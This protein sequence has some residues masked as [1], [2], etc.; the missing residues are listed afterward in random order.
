LP[1]DVP[2]FRKIDCVRLPVDDLDEAIDFY[3]RLGHELIWR[4]SMQ[5]GL[6]LPES[7]AEIVLQT[8]HSELEVDFVVDDADLAA[9]R[10][11]RNGGHLLEGPCDIEIGR[12]AVVEDPFGN[13]LVLLDLRHGGL[14]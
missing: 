1:D 9:D 5:A 4:R 10:F 2:S 6:L 7:E 14:T 3:R 13:R 8:E 11:T 12:C